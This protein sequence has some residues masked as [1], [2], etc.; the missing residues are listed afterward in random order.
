MEL[1]GLTED[2]GDKR[3]IAGFC[4]LAES[5]DRG[6]L[7]TRQ[8]NLWMCAPMHENPHGFPRMRLHYDMQHLKHKLW[9]RYGADYDV[10]T[11]REV[12]PENELAEIVINA[13]LEGR[14]PRVPFRSE[15]LSYERCLNFGEYEWPKRM[16]SYEEECRVQE[17]R[18]H[19]RETLVTWPHPEEWMRIPEHKVAI[20][21]GEELPEVLLAARRREAEA[22]EAYWCRK[23]NPD[24]GQHE[25][26]EPNFDQW[27]ACQARKRKL[28]EER[29]AV[30]L[31]EMLQC[32][33]KT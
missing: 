24:K 11:I 5:Y 29:L 28:E 23:R 10:M 26:Q 7:R 14:E 32:R 8:F 21:E 25:A 22:N 3:K 4:T 6:P 18:R 19:Y 12:Y 16:R 31:L 2:E 27:D 9:K 30:S 33:E 1:W 13:Y 15:E 20:Y 17:R